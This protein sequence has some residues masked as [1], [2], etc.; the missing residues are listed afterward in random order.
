MSIPRPLLEAAPLSEA[1][2]SDV[3]QSE[4]IALAS[5]GGLNLS[6]DISNHRSGRSLFESGTQTLDAIRM[7]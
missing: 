4:D 7:F 1:A 3:M 5:S 2:P 6:K